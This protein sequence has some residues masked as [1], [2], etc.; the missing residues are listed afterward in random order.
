MR[1]QK[2]RFWAEKM[3][4]TLYHNPA[5]SNSRGALALLRARGVEPVIVEYLETPLSRAALAALAR[6]LAQTAGP[7]WP[8]LRAGMMRTKESVYADLALDGASDEAL[9]GAMAAH[10]VLM[11]RPIVVTAK[12]AKLCRPPEGLLALL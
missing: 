3:T 10:P 12:G 1:T 11:N 9:L 6:Q 2:P 7:A 4:V 5:C 8:G